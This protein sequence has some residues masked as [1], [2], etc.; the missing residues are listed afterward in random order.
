MFSDLPLEAV[1]DGEPDDKLTETVMEAAL[2]GEGKV[3]RDSD[4]KLTKETNGIVK[5]LRDKKVRSGRNVTR[6]LAELTKLIN[7][8]KLVMSINWTGN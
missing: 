7:K 2:G 6:V 4:S 3:T 8:G 5:K 1:G